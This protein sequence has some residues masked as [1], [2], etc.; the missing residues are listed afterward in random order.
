MSK[1]FF[2]RGLVRQSVNWLVMLPSKMTALNI[3]N[4]THGNAQRLVCRNNAVCT[5]RDGSRVWCEHEEW[6]RVDRVILL[7]GGQRPLAIIQKNLILEMTAS[8]KSLVF[9]P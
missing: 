6:K 8:L 4:L 5:I 3:V 1:L 9:V 2:I 7:G